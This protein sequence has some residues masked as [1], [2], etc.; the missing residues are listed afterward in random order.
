[1]PNF[2]L[3]GFSNFRMQQNQL[4]GIFRLQITGLHS[5]FD[6]PGLGC[7]SNKLPSE[8]DAAGPGPD[9]ENQWSVDSWEGGWGRR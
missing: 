1:M 3:Q 7:I 9:L 5:R 2:Q 8:A 4:E 6:A